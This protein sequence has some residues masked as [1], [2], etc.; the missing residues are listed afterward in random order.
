MA[1][2]FQV[3]FSSFDIYNFI[4]GWIH[5][6]LALVEMFLNVELLEA[7]KLLRRQKECLGKVRDSWNLRFSLSLSLMPDQMQG[8]AEMHKKGDIHVH[9]EHN[10]AVP[11][12][13]EARILME[14]RMKPEYDL[15]QFVQ[16]RPDRQYE[17]CRN[18]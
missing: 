5:K 11:L 17:Q 8:L 7:H 10:K 6:F 9:S 1:Q 16:D 4:T 14:E 3:S 13:D 15:Y 12:S 18:F 2:I